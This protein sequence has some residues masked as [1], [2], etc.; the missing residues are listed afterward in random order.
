[1]SE[2]DEIDRILYEDDGS[3]DPWPMGD[4]DSESGED[5]PSWLD[6]PT[7]EQEPTAGTSTAVDKSLLSTS[8]I[9]LEKSREGEDEEEIVQNFFAD[10]CCEAKCNTKIPQKLIVETRESCSELEKHQQELL[11][12]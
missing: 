11:I 2:L 5:E 12:I 8:I 4:T 6:R 7:V 1:M 3:N 10:V 9:P